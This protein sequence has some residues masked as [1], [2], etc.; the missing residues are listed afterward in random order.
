MLT[1]I[2]WRRPS[3]GRFAAIA[4]SAVSAAA[5]A[6]LY[7]PLSAETQ[8][9]A[10][11]LHGAYDAPAPGARSLV[12]AVITILAAAVIFIAVTQLVG[13]P[14]HTRLVAAIA[15]VAVGTIAVSLFWL[16]LL[17]PFTSAWIP[18][19]GWSGVGLIAF[20]PCRSAML[21]NQRG[22]GVAR[23][24]DLWLHF[25]AARTPAVSYEGEWHEGYGWLSL[26][27]AS[28]LRM[29]PL[30]PHV[31]HCDNR[32]RTDAVAPLAWHHIGPDDE[33]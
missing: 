21:F 10:D 23:I 20:K 4:F 24:D 5:I 3:L 28:A 32:W 19:D 7:L 16:F 1:A 6:M 25:G 8:R 18:P 11:R 26:S 9:R 14:P 15:G 12:V 31:V 30:D 13:A 17:T 33:R 2:G 22:V 27:E 29:H